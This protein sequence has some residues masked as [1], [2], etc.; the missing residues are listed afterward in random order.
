[1]D[2]NTCKICDEDNIELIDGICDECHIFLEKWGNN[3]HAM[4]DKMENLS[5]LF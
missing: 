3:P 4:S 5:D 2:N 1:M